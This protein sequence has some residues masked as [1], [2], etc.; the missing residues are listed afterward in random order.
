MASALG[1]KTQDVYLIGCEPR[2]LRSE[3]D[4]IG[5][6]KGLNEAVAKA[7][8]MIHTLIHDLVDN[9]KPGGMIPG[10]KPQNRKERQEQTSRTR[11]KAGLFEKTC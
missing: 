3:D 1:I 5:L 10:L 11:V 2:T 9:P 8:V 6:S 4:R 7:I